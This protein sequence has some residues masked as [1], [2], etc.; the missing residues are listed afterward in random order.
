MIFQKKMNTFVSSNIKI[1]KKTKLFFIAATILL[2]SAC[3][4]S[5]GCGCLS[6]ETLTKFVVELVK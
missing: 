1:M 6:M 3:G 5:K 4:A 2:L